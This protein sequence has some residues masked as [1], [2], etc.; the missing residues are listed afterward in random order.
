MGAMTKRNNQTTKRMFKINSMVKFGARPMATTPQN[1]F[2]NYAVVMPGCL[3]PLLQKRL[4]TVHMGRLYG[5][6]P[7][8]DLS[9][10][11]LMDLDTLLTEYDTDF[12]FDQEHYLTMDGRQLSLVKRFLQAERVVVGQLRSPLLTATSNQTYWSLVGQLLLSVIRPTQVVNLSF[13]P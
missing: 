10:Q 7:I 13:C 1:F 9:I 12:D 3:V 5:L 11:D 6:P 4:T 2:N 8:H